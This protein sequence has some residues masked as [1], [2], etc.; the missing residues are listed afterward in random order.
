MFALSL[1]AGRVGATILPGFRIERIADVSGFIS[2]IVVDSRGAIYY[3]TTNGT[4][5][6]LDRDHSAAIAIVATNATGNS[7]LLGMAL[8]DDNTAVVHYTRPNQT[9]DVISRI[10][11]ATGRET[12]VHEFAGDIGNPE[13][14]VSSEHHGGNPIVVDGAIIVGIGDYGAVQI[15]AFPE[16]NGGKIFRI[17]PDGSV[18]QLARGFRN[19]FDMAWDPENH[20]LI[21]PDNGDAIDDEINV[22]GAPGQY[23][24]WPQTMGNEPAVDGAVPPVYVFPE[25]NA[26]TGIARLSGR[27][28]MLRHGYLLCTYV[29]H[30]MLF[31]DNIDEP[32]PIAI[33]KGE[34]AS[35]IDVAEGPNGEIFFA[36]GTTIYRLIPPLRGDCNGDGVV[37]VNDIAALDRELADGVPHDV[38][39]AQDGAFKGSWGCDADGDG[40]ITQSDRG[41]LLRLL[42]NRFPAVRRR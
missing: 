35:L 38:H 11:L 28:A 31:F 19:P 2:S 37:D 25:V 13:H 42:T 3:T 27:N 10:D 12:V 1:L 33:V 41:A 21:A 4:I 9:Y 8:A 24:G 39:V 15:A 40:L 5:F 36:T 6:R 16:W 18:E 14:G 20:V 34:T 23:Y 17:D 29:T 22:V 32:K 30:A 7:G 26:P